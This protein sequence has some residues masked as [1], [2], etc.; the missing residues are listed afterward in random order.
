MTIKATILNTTILPLGAI[1]LMSTGPAPAEA[2]PDTGCAALAAETISLTGAAATA[3]H[4][5]GAVPL[6]AGETLRLQMT[7]PPGDAAIGAILLSDGGET[8]ERLISGAA[9]QQI[10]YTIPIDGL[11]SFEYRADGRNEITF[12]ISCDQRSALATPIAPEAFVQR[13]TARLLTNDTAQAS[14]Q[15]RAS[16]PHSIDQAVKTGAVVDAEGKPAQVTM[17]TSVQNLAAA[18]GRALNDNKLDVWIEGRVSQSQQRVE[19]NGTK[20]DIKGQSGTLFMGADYL[21]TPGLMIGSLMQVDRYREAYDAYGTGASDHGIMVG[22]YASI[23]LAPD[24]F[25]D[26]RAA[27][28]TGEND[29]KSLNGTRLAFETERQLLRGQLSGNRDLF[30]LKFTPSIGLAMIENRAADPAALPPGTLGDENPILGRLGMGSGV[31]YRIA[32]DDGAYLQPNAALS[33]GWTVDS[34]DKLD[35]ANA[36]LTNDTGAKAEAGLAL[37]TAD[38]ISIQATGAVEGIGKDDY[39]AWS[40]RLTLKAPLN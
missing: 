30:G 26:A 10:A 39:S 35:V 40:G 18:D 7:A 19:D 8:A 15:R 29:A 1:L 31:A 5:T 37:G 33:T 13:S 17:S 4:S 27:W 34:L 28:G 9:P 16:K 24:V 3:T 21:L 32:L 20:Y 38:G 22:P 12:Q 36:H 23:R 14:L 6:R 11:Y 2:A 25:F